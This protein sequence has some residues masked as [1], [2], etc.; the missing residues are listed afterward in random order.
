MPFRANIKYR[1]Q[2]D[3]TVNTDSASYKAGYEAASGKLLWT[4]SDDKYY[5][6]S[7][8]LNLSSYSGV[9]I[10]VAYSPDQETRMYY[11]YI[12]VG[13]SGFVSNGP[14]GLYRDVS[15][16][17]TGVFFTSYENSNR[18]LPRSIYGVLLN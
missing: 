1:N 15:V 18:S 14:D 2:A 7:A 12:P 5:T 16:S 17:A 9:V 8:S 13:S 4:C 6:G 10:G 11:Y 3:A